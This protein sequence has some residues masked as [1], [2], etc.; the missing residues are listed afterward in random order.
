MTGK[1]YVNPNQTSIKITSL[2]YAL[3]LI[4]PAYLILNES[5]FGVSQNTFLVIIAFVI[6]VLLFSAI[7]LSKNIE[8]DL[9]V[10]YLIVSIS[11]LF[12]I[13]KMLFGMQYRITQFAFYFLIP[14]AIS[15]LKFDRKKVLVYVMYFSFPLLLGIEKM[16]VVTNLGLNQADMYNTYSF[17][18]FIIGAFT[19]FFFYQEKNLFLI[20]GYIVNFYFLI[21]I[22][23]NA[24]RGFWGVILFFIAILILFFVRRHSTKKTYYGFLALVSAFLTIIVININNIVV[25]LLHF[26]GDNKKVNIS[27]LAK[28][29]RLIEGGD[30]SNGRIDIW[31]ECLRCIWSN[32]FW[33][34]GI[35]GI[36]RWSNGEIIYPHNFILQL[37]VDGGIVWGIFPL[38]IVFKGVMQLIFG[39]TDKKDEL[40]FLIFIMSQSIPL[41]LLSGDIWKSASFWIAVFYTIRMKKLERK[42]D[43]L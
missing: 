21:R 16:M 3:V 5:V 33:G 2:I 1:V 22:S 30:L 8:V 34:Y 35:D 15:M 41:A 36:K 43:V 28:M 9:R 42:V 27:V 29:N 25:L 4:T 13:S 6:L 20:I 40:V 32:P 26:L 39:N 18:T 24:V 17:V 19:L 37:L 10:L 14:G 23:K 11:V 38:I 31:N 7:I 12:I